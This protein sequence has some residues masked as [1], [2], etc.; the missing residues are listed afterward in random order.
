MRDDWYSK[1]NTAN[2]YGKTT[3][4]KPMFGTQS[5][6]VQSSPKMASSSWVKSGRVSSPPQTVRASSSR[7]AGGSGGR[8][9]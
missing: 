9:K 3:T 7:Q 2:Y 4:G 1:R 8:G 6:R 5:T